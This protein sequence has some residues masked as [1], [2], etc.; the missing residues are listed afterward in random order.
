MARRGKGRKEKRA[1]RTIFAAWRYRVNKALKGVKERIIDEE[2][3]KGTY[4]EFKDGGFVTT[5]SQPNIDSKALAWA[6]AKASAVQSW[7]ISTGPGHWLQK[8]AQTTAAAMS[9]AWR[10]NEGT[11]PVAP[12]MMTPHDQGGYYDA[13]GNPVYGTG[14]FGEGTYFGKFDNIQPKMTPYPKRTQ[15]SPIA[16]NFGNYLLRMGIKDPRGQRLAQ[17]ASYGTLAPD[18]WTEQKLMDELRKTYKVSPDPGKG[19]SGAFGAVQN[20]FSKGYGY[21]QMAFLAGQKGSAGAFAM[22]QLWGSAAQDIYK[23]ADHPITKEIVPKITE[24]MPFVKSVDAGVKALNVFL[25]GLRIAGPIAQ[26]GSTWI[27]LMEQHA[28]TTAERIKGIG[29][30]YATIRDTNMKSYAR[31]TLE[32]TR[33]NY[34]IR[35]KY[36]LQG[37]HDFWGLHDPEQEIGAELQGRVSM[38]DYISKNLHLTGARKDSVMAQAGGSLSF[39]MNDL[40]RGEAARPALERLRGELSRVSTIEALA[41]EDVFNEGWW[42]GG[43]SKYIYTTNAYKASV[44]RMHEKYIDEAMA[45]GGWFRGNAVGPKEEF[46]RRDELYKERVKNIPLASRNRMQLEIERRERWN[47]AERQRRA[48]Q[49]FD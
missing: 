7:F 8:A 4:K 35:N 1:A 13:Q 46:D 15:Y 26:I 33:R 12:P 42:E 16:Q 40:E 23:I 21:A 47:Q 37:A 11:Y 18:Y 41:R 28:E 19:I 27:G 29:G 6:Q 34:A 43:F 25:A 39:L 48:V 24:W 5:G 3:S 38:A 10:G 31:D 32:K 9:Q 49:N 44:K 17:M 20:V 30:Q 22:G 2:I 45:G 36:T 14:G